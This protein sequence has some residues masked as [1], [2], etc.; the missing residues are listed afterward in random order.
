MCEDEQAVHEYV[1]Q[2]RELVIMRR[3]GG[4]VNNRVAVREGHACKVPE[5]DHKAPLL[6]EH[7][8]GRASESEA[9]SQHVS[10]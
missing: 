8:L 10:P 2:C 1:S 9:Q 6:I 5:D 3:V 4:H 7:V